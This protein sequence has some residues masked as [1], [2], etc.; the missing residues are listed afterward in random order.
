MN[1]NVIFSY[2]YL[3]F[4]FAMKYHVALRILSTMLE[5]CTIAYKYISKIYNNVFWMLL[6]SWIDFCP[7]LHRHSWKPTTLKCNA[8]N[9][10]VSGIWYI[11]KLIL[12]NNHPKCFMDL[13]FPNYTSFLCKLMCCFIESCCR[14]FPYFTNS[15][16]IFPLWKGS[17]YALYIIY[18]CVSVY[19]YNYMHMY[20]IQHVIIEHNGFIY[21]T[22]NIF[23]FCFYM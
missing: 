7:Y 19:E 15:K 13:I 12:L 20:N 10:I 21:I 4:M 6:E 8:Y 3:C 16:S 5:K 9:K 23:F 1:V 18:M 22:R 17:Y 2:I 14:Q 11:L